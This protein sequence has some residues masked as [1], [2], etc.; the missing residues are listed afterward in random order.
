MRLY[1]LP[2]AFEALASESDGELSPE[3]LAKIDQLELALEQKVDG[4]CRVI[5][6]LQAKAKAYK[7]E[8]ERLAKKAKAAADN[9]DR[10][11]LYVHDNLKRLG[12][13]RVDGPLFAVWLHPSP[14]SVKVTVPVQDLPPEWLEVKIEPNKK[15]ILAAFKD[16][17]PLPEGVTVETT[18]THLRIS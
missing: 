16:G 17:Q 11:A 1:E 18:N 10:L 5:R 2:P 12:H 15:T 6:T 3:A 4:C 14:P 7:E 13:R 8:A 9:A